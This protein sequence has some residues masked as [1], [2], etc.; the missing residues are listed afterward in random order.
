MELLELKANTRKATGKG[1]ARA[2]RRE[3]RIPAILYGPKTDPVP[4]SV[5]I[6]DIERLLKQSKSSQML[7]SLDLGDGGAARSAMIK[8]LQSEPVSQDFRH[9]D[10]YEVAM[11]KKIKVKVPIVATGKSIGVEVGGLLQIVRRELEVFCLPHEIPDKIEID[12][13]DL[14]I[15]DSVH[16]EEIVLEGDVEVP[17]DVNFTIVTVLTPKKEEE[18][19]EEEEE[20]LEG[21]EG[22]EGAEDAEAEGEESGTEE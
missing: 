15:G 6:Y 8:E 14:D 1:H 11:D 16:V 13:T 7:V 9:I 19:V 12:I 2:L 4:L 18:I 22:E 3:G 21:V 10:F 5:S 17:A 20:G